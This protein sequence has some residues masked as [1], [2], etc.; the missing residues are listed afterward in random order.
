VWKAEL[1]EKGKTGNHYPKSREGKINPE[2]LKE[3]A[4]KHPGWHLREFAA[5]FGVRLQ[6]I[7]KR[8]KSF[9]VARKKKFYVFRKKR[10]ETG[11]VL[12]EAKEML[13]ENRACADES[14]INDDVKR[15]YGRALR[16]VMSGDGKRGR[17]FHRVNA[18][19]GQ[20]RGAD[21]VRRPPPLC[22]Q[23]TMNGVR[24]EKSL[25]R[26]IGKGKTVIM[27]R[28]RFHRKT[29]LEEIRKRREVFLV[30]LPPYSPDF[31]PIEKTW[32]NMKKDL[33]SGAPL[34]GLIESSI[35]AYL[36]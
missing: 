28:A 6:A 21:D 22:C 31:N 1:E 30:Y 11:S 23:G 7:D 15:E 13:P 17:K 9:G 16:G 24:F 33:R 10:R 35:Y 34:H 26:T 18:V 19:A 32:A 36:S 4:E 3:T 8:F 14:G 27:D 25:L 5:E 2:R 20:T 12:K 29:K